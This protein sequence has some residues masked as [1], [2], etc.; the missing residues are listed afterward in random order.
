MI[1]TVNR[2]SKEDHHRYYLHRR[3]KKK[4]SVHARQRVIEIP[5]FDFESF[6]SIEQPFKRY[7]I[8]LL[9]LPKKYNLQSVIG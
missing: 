4:Y 6:E 3:L 5:H 8:E 9:N 1:Q 2:I 7:L